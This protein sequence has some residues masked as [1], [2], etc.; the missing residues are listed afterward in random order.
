MCYYLELLTKKKKFS[1]DMHFT[2][3]LSIVVGIHTV[4]ILSSMPCVPTGTISVLN[5]EDANA[6]VT[7]GFGFTLLT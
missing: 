2:S 6:P 1:P 4:H 5:A 7:A 3:L